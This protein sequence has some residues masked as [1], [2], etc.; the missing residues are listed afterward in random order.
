M[1]KMFAMHRLQCIGRNAGVSVFMGFINIQM[2]HDTADHTLLWQVVTRIGVPPQ[3]L[4]NIRHF[5][6]GMIA[7]VRPGDGVCSGWFEVEQ[8]LQ[9]NC[10]LSPAVFE[11]PFHSRTD[12]CI[13][14]R[15]RLRI[16]RVR[17]PTLLVVS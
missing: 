8:V 4:V 17:L 9:K 3:I 2:A 16:N 1:N 15:Y 13:V 5:H 14:I 12:C 7:C 10:L 6:D 11:D